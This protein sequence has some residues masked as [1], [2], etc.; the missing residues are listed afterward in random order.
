MDEI[1]QL[2]NRIAQLEQQ[3]KQQG[4]YN[5][6]TY[7]YMHEEKLNPPAY[8]PHSNEVMIA[9]A[10]YAMQ[11]NVWD[12][13]YNL[14]NYIG[15]LETKELPKGYTEQELASEAK[16]SLKKWHSALDQ[17]DDSKDIW[18]GLVEDEWFVRAFVNP[19][20]EVHGGD[21]TAMA[22]SCCRCHAEELF[23]IPFTAN[24]TKHEGYALYHQY[25]SD[26]K[27]KNNIK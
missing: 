11:E 24:W 20:S 19:L 3:V 26:Y 9:K 18:D 17:W 2:K 25:Y 21:C 6:P 16:R 10:R 8:M 7:Q 12:M 5:N 22:A 4:S 13:M 1:T 27:E 23:K 15:Y 14:E